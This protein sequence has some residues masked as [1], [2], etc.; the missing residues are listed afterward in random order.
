MT[1]V[2]VRSV[3]FI[4]VLTEGVQ[5]HPEGHD[6]FLQVT[7]TSDVF[8]LSLIAVVGSLQ[9]QL[10][11]LGV[12]EGLS[13]CDPSGSDDGSSFAGFDVRGDVGGGSVVGVKRKRGPDP[14]VDSSG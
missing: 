2:L 10:R 3:Q 6:G 9:Q 14:D 1:W 7:S 13:S 8:C 4:A 5:G 11:G 12:S